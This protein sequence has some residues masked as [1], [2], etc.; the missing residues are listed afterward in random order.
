[1]QA[2]RYNQDGHAALTFA[3]RDTRTRLVEADTSGPFCVQRV[4][5]LD[6][7][8]P[9]LATVFLTNATAGIFAGDRLRITVRVEAGARALITSRSATKVHTM[10]DGSASQHTGLTVEEGGLLEYLLE[11]LIPFRGSR[12]SQTTNITV[13]KGG[14]LVHADI[15]APGRLAHGEAM[16]YERYSHRLLVS[17]EAGLP[18]Y[19]EAYELQPPD[20]NLNA[21]GVLDSR[22]MTVGT[23]IAVLPEP[24]GALLPAVRT[25]LAAS[26][27][28]AAA[29]LLPSG[30]GVVVKAMSPSLESVRS[31]LYSA[32]SEVRA[33]LYNCPPPNLR[34]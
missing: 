27:C 1:M 21:L 23:L 14:T 13:H 10:P 12:F 22:D 18:L 11:P 24:V 26:P 25:R 4:L 5:Y 3:R 30:H 19:A 33:A 32:W 7:A 29:S 34:K 2:A 28:P 20:G 17:D 16:E 9:D 31:V 8:L 15:F 6:S